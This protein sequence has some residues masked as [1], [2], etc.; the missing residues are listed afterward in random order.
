M[1]VVSSKAASTRY[2]R[3]GGCEKRPTLATKVAPFSVVA[4]AMRGLNEDR[5]ASVLFE[6]SPP[7]LKA[8]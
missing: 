1:R 8:S 3:S 5:A 7:G 4:I 6:R 2:C